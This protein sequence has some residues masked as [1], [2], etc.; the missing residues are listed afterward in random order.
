MVFEVAVH[1]DGI[2]SVQAK[3]ANGFVWVGR[4]MN[5]VTRLTQLLDERSGTTRVVVDI[6]H[7]CHSSNRETF[8]AR[9]TCYFSDWNHKRQAADGYSGCKG[10]AELY[11]FQC[12]SRLSSY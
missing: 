6:E 1:N 8:C 11:W 9:S 2:H 7:R 4:N 12:L 10:R 5:L 3:Q